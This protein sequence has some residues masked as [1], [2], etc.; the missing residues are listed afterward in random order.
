M[1]SAC[2]STPSPSTAWS[3]VAPTTDAST[4]RRPATCATGRVHVHRHRRGLGGYL[5]PPC[6]G[7]GPRR[8]QPQPVALSRTTT[9]TPSSRTAPPRSMCS[10]NDTDAD[11]DRLKIRDWDYPA[12]PSG[13]T[14]GT[15]DCTKLF[16][17]RCT[18][19]LDQSYPGPLPLTET[20][21]YRITDRH[22]RH[23]A[24]DG[25]RDRDR[26]R[27]PCAG[28]R[29]RHCRH[30]GSGPGRDQ[31]PRQR[32]RSRRGSD[33]SRR[34]RTETPRCSG[35]ATCG[36]ADCHYEPPAELAPSAYPFEDGFTYTIAD[37]RG[38]TRFCPR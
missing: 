36:A 37:P 27:K 14:H 5:D 20:F 6:D 16:Q 33:R 1:R 15:L 9:R 13:T 4:T 31:R 11:G 32:R 12:E 26:R 22:P 17:T 23:H 30:T 7:H 8:R 2:S 3:P 10:R 29:G 25:H 34:P 18:Y 24:I 28:R 35:P 38:R 19:T 21:T